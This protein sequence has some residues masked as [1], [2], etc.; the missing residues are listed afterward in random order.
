M[1][2]L[3]E[4]EEGHQK[5]WSGGAQLDGKTEDVVDLSSIQEIKSGTKYRFGAYVRSGSSATSSQVQMVDFGSNMV[6]VFT[7]SIQSG[8][9]VTFDGYERFGES[10][11]V[12]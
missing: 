3:V 11:A 5:V 7:W 9:N 1:H 6:G 4:D 12:V 10:P 8:S 2:F